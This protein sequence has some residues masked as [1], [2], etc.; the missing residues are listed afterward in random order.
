MRE[1]FCF[2]NSFS[3]N[4]NKTATKLCVSS[5]HG[6]IHVF[7]LD[8]PEKNSRSTLANA[9][10]L[11]KYFQSKWSC[12]KFEVNNQ[13]KCICAFSQNLDQHSIIG[14]FDSYKVKSSLLRMSCQLCHSFLLIAICTDGTYYKYTLDN[15]N[16]SKNCQLESCTKFLELTSRQQNEQTGDFFLCESCQVILLFI[17]SNKEFSFQ[18]LTYIENKKNLF[19]AYTTQIFAKW[20]VIKRFH[21]EKKTFFCCSS[22]LFYEKNRPSH[23]TTAIC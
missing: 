12:F 3:I 19:A 21:I 10:F 23:R 14:K 6:T 15:V 4:F 16:S 1:K 20:Q 5:D 22:I 7:V 11:P 9:T 13:S 18:L 17:K 8:V 2:Q